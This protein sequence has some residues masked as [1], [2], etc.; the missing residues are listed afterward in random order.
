MTEEPFDILAEPN[1]QQALEEL[2]R[3]NAESIIHL[4][5][6]V[7]ELKVQIATIA[8]ILETLLETK[9]VHGLDI[10]A[11]FNNQT[12]EIYPHLYSLSEKVDASF[13]KKRNYKYTK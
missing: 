13:K 12:K 10:E 11:L 6:E 7:K 1:P 2:V 4:H 3:G 9:K 8:R 5:E